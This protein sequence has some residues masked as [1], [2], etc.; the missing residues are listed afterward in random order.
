V[1]DHDRLEAAVPLLRTGYRLLLWLEDAMEKGFVEPETAHR[2]VSLEESA[3]AWIERHWSNLPPD[4]RPELEQLEPFSRLFS[5]F[6]TS[7]FDLHPEPGERL[8]S[9]DAHCFCPMCRGCARS[10]S[11]PPIGGAPTR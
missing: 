6:L 8:F 2:Y 11:L 1:L 7:T 3:R 5:T 9:P 4:A 10:D